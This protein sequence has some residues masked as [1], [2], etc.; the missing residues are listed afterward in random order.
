LLID[1]NPFLQ[2]PDAFLNILD[3]S[4]RFRK[5]GLC[6]CN[7]LGNLAGGEECADMAPADL[8]IL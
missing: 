7:L 1:F 2:F 3:P 8:E 4:L 5:L 6:R